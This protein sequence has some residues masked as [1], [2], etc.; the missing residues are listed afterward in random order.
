MITDINRLSGLQKAAIL[1]S[2]LGEGLALTLVKELSKTD[3]RKVRAS[4]RELDNVSFAVKKR[5]MEE[6]YFSFVSE[7]FHEEESDEPKKPFNFLEEITDEQLIALVKPEA[8]SVAA[9]ALA[10][11]SGERRN[12]IMSRLP[13]ESKGNII[14]EMGNLNEI[15]LEAIVN[16]ANDL[17]KKSKF[18]PK[19]IAF[20]RGGGKD[21]AEILG[22]LSSDEE[23]QFLEN[24]SRENP[25]LA[26]EVKKYHLTWDVLF[27][28]LPD[29]T[30][31]DLM[32]SVEL[33]TIA[34][35]LKGMPEDIVNRVIENLPKKKQAMFEPVEGAVAKREVDG[36]R[37]DIVA[38]A[39]QLE[40][41]GAFNL[42]DLVGGGEMVE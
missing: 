20:S 28:I 25:D 6:F 40:K 12:K 23:T 16:V 10:Q 22:G 17:H 30:I 14:M 34:L 15:P 39:R 26:A 8:D 42:A 36:A 9:I 5:V 38:A 37:K 33:D 19:T 35:A 3:I 31:R 1:F 13:S 41:D 2:V 29:S 32:N 7:K 4:M 21:V 27:E 18:L 24:I 11:I